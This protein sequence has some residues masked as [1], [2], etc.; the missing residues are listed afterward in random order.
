[1]SRATAIRA[2]SAVLKVAE[3]SGIHATLKGLRH[4]FVLS[5]MENKT[6]P[7]VIHKLI[8]WFQLTC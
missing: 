5:H 4:S 1:M 7:V 2:L 3:V 6:P 8:E